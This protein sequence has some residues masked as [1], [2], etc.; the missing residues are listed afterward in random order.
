MDSLK[1]SSR[2]HWIFRLGV[3]MCFIGHGSFGLISKPVWCNYFA[4]FGIDQASAYHLMPLVGGADVLLGVITLF[5]PMRIIA[6]WLVFWGF[7]TASLRPLSGE[8]FAELLERAGNFGTPILLLTMVGV[9]GLHTKDWFTPIPREV[10]LTEQSKS[11]LLRWM[12]VLAFLLLAGHGWLNLLGKEALVDQYARLGFANPDHVAWIV[13][14]FEIL[15]GVAILVKPFRQL[16]L[17]LFIWKVGCEL[18]Y[19]AWP[20]FEWIERGGSYAVL[21]GLYVLIDSGYVPAWKP[22]FFK[23]LAGG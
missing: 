21:L 8:P 12:R 9:R 14:I 4:V 13:G 1:L 11:A 3:A 23:S 15:G 20:V 16:V 10:K 22:A 6:A 7:V 17:V 19:P 18:F 2:L 5:L